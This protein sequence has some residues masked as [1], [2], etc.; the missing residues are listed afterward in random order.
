MEAQEPAAVVHAAANCGEGHPLPIVQ[1][2]LTQEFDQ[3]QRD[4]GVGEVAVIAE[5]IDQF[6]HR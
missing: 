1:V 2:A 5:I 6:V 4:T 3:R